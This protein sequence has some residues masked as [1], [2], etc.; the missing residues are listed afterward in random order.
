M[1]QDITHCDVCDPLIGAWDVAPHVMWQNFYNDLAGERLSYAEL[2]GSV[3]K[4][5]KAK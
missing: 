3:N 5:S 2:L 4:I 1:I